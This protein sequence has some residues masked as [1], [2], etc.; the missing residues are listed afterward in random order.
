MDWPCPR[1]ARSR[2]AKSS[3]ESGLDLKPMTMQSPA[4]SGGSGGAAG[5]EGE[6]G[7]AGGDVGGIGGD[8][9]G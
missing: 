1:G 4:E 9:G 7:G 8:S 3:S 2:M 6:A 5:G